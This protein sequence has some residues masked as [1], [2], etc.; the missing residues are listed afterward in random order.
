MITGLLTP[1]LSPTPTTVLA[2]LNTTLLLNAFQLNLTALKKTISLLVDQRAGIVLRAWRVVQYTEMHVRETA[3]GV[4]EYGLE[5]DVEQLAHNVRWAMGVVEK[6]CGVT[7]GVKKAVSTGSLKVKGKPG[8]SAI[9]PVLLAEQEE[10]DAVAAWMAE[11]RECERALLVSHTPTVSPAERQE[12]ARE[13]LWKEVWAS[14]AK[15]QPKPVGKCP[16]A[17][18]FAGSSVDTRMLWSVCEDFEAHTAECPECF[19]KLIGAG[20][21]RDFGVIGVDGYGGVVLPRVER[22]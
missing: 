18:Q 9:H 5:A 7:L 12:A 8:T 13:A 20:L 10:R 4:R 11:Q 21:G 6:A 2:T 3:K 1:P 22:W 14:C 19:D 15:P 16:R 17:K